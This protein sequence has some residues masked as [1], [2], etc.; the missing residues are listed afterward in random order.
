M[1]KIYLPNI[2]GKGYADFWKFKGRFRVVK[3]SRASKK[4]TT[5]ALNLIYRMMQ[6]PQANALVVRKTF[7]TLKDSCY[8]QLKWAIRRLGVEKY[9][10][11]RLSPLEIEYIPT[12]QKILFRGMDDPL[13]ITSITVEVGVLCWGWIEE[14]Y[15]VDDE[16]AFNRLDES[17][18]GK[19]PDG[20]FIQW[21]ITFN[22][23][24]R[25]HWLKARFFDRENS[26]VLAKTT[27][28]LCNEFLSPADMAMFED[29]KRNDPER[30][31]VAGL[32]KNLLSI[33]ASKRWNSIRGQYRA[34]LLLHKDGWIWKHGKKS[35]ALKG[36]T[37]Y[38]TLVA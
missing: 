38:Q 15:E 10:K 3:G 8:M 35:K 29:M 33:N 27:N 5:A 9:W 18:R 17:L 13:K 6:Y 21:T 1:N 24:D 7:A 14:A 2:L 32:G 25:N 31:K 19:L 22:P 28:Y 11:A 30:Y 20:Y 34:K 37:K 36:F 16:D 12:G 26:N 23:W 4:S